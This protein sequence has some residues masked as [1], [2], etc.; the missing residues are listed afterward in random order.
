MADYFFPAD[1]VIGTDQEWLVLEVH[2][3]VFNAWLTAWMTDDEN[4]D[5]FYSDLQD[6]ISEM[7]F[8]WGQLWGHM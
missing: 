5:R 6:W 2:G 1:T 7:T 3:E 4:R 8:G